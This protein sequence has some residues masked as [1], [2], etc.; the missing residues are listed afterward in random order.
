[1]FR[2]AIRAGVGMGLVALGCLAGCSGKGGGGGLKTVPVTGTVTYKGAPAAGATVMFS[3]AAGKGAAAVGV[4]DS[5]G[6]FKLRAQGGAEGAVPGS[7]RVTV[8]KTE[9]A[10]A[11]A[12]PVEAKIEGGGAPAKPADQLPAKYKSAETS[13]LT[14]EVKP[15][16][17]NHFKFDLTD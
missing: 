2:L 16:G 1:M 14:A 12:E 15:E 10:G 17:T 8:F 9:S 11:T 7:Y 3:P 6:N 13:K 4:T 5:Q